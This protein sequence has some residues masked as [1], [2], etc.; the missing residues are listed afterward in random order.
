VSFG[1][2]EVIQVLV[3][4]DG[5]LSPRNGKLNSKDGLFD[6]TRNDKLGVFL[7]S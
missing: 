7:T 6:Y 3:V 4:F 1:S 2:T 5:K